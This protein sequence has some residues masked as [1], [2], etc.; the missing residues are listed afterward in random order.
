MQFEVDIKGGKDVKE[1]IGESGG[2]GMH[3]GWF[4]QGRYT[5]ST[6]VDFLH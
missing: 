5:L 6:K 1:D 3:E 2:G 4:E